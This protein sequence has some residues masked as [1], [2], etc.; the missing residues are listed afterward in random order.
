MT[1]ENTVDVL[2]VTALEKERDAVLCYL[3]SPQPFEIKNHT[4]HK[5]YL[6][7]EAF[8]SGY[9]VAVLCFGGMGN[10]RAAIAV[11]QA[12]EVC[13]PSA[14][15]LTGI[16]GGVANQ[17]L[18]LGDLIIPNQIVGYESGKTQETGNESR[19]EVLRPTHHI[20]EKAR[21][22][23]RNK[24]IFDRQAISRPGEM[25]GEITPKIHIGVV[26]SGE[27]VIADN[28]TIPD[29]KKS[30]S[31]LIGIEMEGFGAA[32]A[33][34]QANS[35][36]QIL[37][38]KGICDWADPKKNDEWQSY[39]ADVAAIYVVNFLKSKP[40]ECLENIETK[41]KP[42]EFKMNSDLSGKVKIQLQ[43][44]LGNSWLELAT[45]LSIPA[46]DYK[47]FPQG[48][49]C[50]FILE[51]LRERGQFHELSNALIEIERQDLASLLRD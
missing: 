28:Q 30:W 11:T 17:D 29:L 23:S 39:A 47:K 13:K 50:L 45:Y 2:I 31:K 34:Y 36:H 12:I 20:L 42:I 19:F 49:E 33:V 51:W 43:S 26:A 18:S 35:Y 1:D 40:I 7:H 6:Q 37:M 21:H 46:S 14:I 5:S 41:A 48:S 8:N 32:L 44:R 38:V 9:Q 10:V 3:N 25:S 16:M 24:Y 4:A 15:I 27:K 22:F